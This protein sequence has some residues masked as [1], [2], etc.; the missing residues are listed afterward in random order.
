MS[1]ARSAGISHIYLSLGLKLY[2]LKLFIYPPLPPFFLV[3]LLHSLALTSFFFFILFFVFFCLMELMK[4]LTTLLL[5][6]CLPEWQPP[7]PIL[8]RYRWS[9]GGIL[10]EPEVC[11]PLRPN[12]L[13]SCHQPCGQVRGL[14]GTK[15]ELNQLWGHFRFSIHF[16]EF[17][18]QIEIQFM[19]WKW[20]YPLFFQEFLDLLP[21]L[22]EYT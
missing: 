16:S 12:Q 7:K 18:N 8:C 4:D 11:L 13:L 9:D 2:W 1:S 17:A 3:I 5:F 6:L 21:E 20:Y 15:L 10:P 19:N 14:W 22:T